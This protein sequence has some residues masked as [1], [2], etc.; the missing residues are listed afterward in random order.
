MRANSKDAERSTSLLGLENRELV[1]ASV[2][3]N[4]QNGC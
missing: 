4:D 3:A 2:A 1:A